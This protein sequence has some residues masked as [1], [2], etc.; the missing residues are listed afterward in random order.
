MGIN[1]VFR[2]EVGAALSSVLDPRMVLSRLLSRI[3]STSSVCLRF[4]DPYGDAVFNYLQAVVLADELTQA[5]GHC[6][7]T[8]E[9]RHIRRIRELA[10]KCASGRHTYLWFE[11]D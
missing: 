5:E 1:V 10:K 8:E 6:E 7:T 4:V 9:R 11:G 3:D 2:D